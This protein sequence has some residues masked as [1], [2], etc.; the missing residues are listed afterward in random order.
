MSKPR[1]LIVDDEPLART[2]VRAL[3]RDDSSVE[4]IGECSN[5]IEA[6]AAIRREQPEI[7]FLDVQMPGCDGLEL[8]AELPPQK[9][10]AIIL[11][12]AHD[13]F[14][15]DAFSAQV[16]DYLLKPFDRERFRTALKRAVDYVNAQRTG[17]LAVR[18]ESVLSTS[19]ARRPRRLLVK[20]DGRTIFITPDDIVWVEAE[21]NYSVL[22]LTSTKRLL[23]RETLSSLEKRLG[24]SSF[25]R[26]NRSA[27]A[28][29][30]QV[31]ELLHG[32]YGDHLVLLRNGVRLPL[33]RNLRSRFE[34]LVTN[35]E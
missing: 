9:R 12:T 26:V 15:I 3:L 31:Q 21:S 14:A 7:V 25:A 20:S 35:D 23:L 6:L 34:K 13:R 28:H 29:V 24:A 30:D 1:I 19:P 11:A 10:P 8:L 16:V 18:I 2:R 33:S 5:G 17:D 22:H 4:I 32:K 27:L